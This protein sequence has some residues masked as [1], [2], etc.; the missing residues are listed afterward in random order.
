MKNIRITDTESLFVEN[1]YKFFT[2]GD[3]TKGNTAVY[4]NFCLLFSYKKS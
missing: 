2:S 1:F 3:A 4:Q